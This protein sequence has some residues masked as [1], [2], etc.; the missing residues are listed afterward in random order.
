[1]NGIEVESLNLNPTDY[2]S[3]TG[4]KSVLSFKIYRN[5]NDNNDWYYEI[6]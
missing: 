1:L 3:S 2:P 5:P 4:A 6:P